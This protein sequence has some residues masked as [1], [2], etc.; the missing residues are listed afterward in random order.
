MS[1]LFFLIQCYSD[2]I[3]FYLIYLQLILKLVKM[4]F[5]SKMAAVDAAFIASALMTFVI[6][7]DRGYQ[8][9]G[10]AY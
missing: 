9:G 3:K 10:G 8:K 6:E 4:S 2:E 5:K 1:F 7:G